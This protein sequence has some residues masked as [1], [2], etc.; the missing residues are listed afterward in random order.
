M[1]V[2]TMLVI[3][4][5][6]FKIDF[7]PANPWPYFNKGS[8]WNLVTIDPG[9]QVW[10]CRRTTDDGACQSCNLYP[11]NLNLK[12]KLVPWR[13]NPNIKAFISRDAK[14]LSF[15]KTGK[16]IEIKRHVRLQSFTTSGELRLSVN[17]K[18]LP[19]E[20]LCNVRAVTSIGFHL[21][22]KTDR[23][24]SHQVDRTQSQFHRRFNNVDKV[25]KVAEKLGKLLLWYR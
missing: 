7:V 20:T 5:R 13:I 6:S 14:L 16:N 3:W 24:P 17:M 18:I 12:I 15:L 25:N 1:N 19:I 21:V 9:R 2:K 11:V 22:S 4:P 8:I 23:L 10:N